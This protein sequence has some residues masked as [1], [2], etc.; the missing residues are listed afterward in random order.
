MKTK[1]NYR[2]I[3]YDVMDHFANATVR[4]I[5]V[6]IIFVLMWFF[7]A[8]VSINNE[9]MAKG[10]IDTV[11]L[12]RSMDVMK[13]MSMLFLVIGMFGFAC[14]AYLSIQNIRIK[15]SIKKYNLSVIK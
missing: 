12:Y 8:S 4:Y 14:F 10:T 11:T 6:A 9:L 3:I 7:L 1:L 2:R 13:E 5:L 15:Q